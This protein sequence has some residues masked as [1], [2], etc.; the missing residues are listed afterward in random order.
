MLQPTGGWG[1][2]TGGLPPSLA[3][4]Q[5][6]AATLTIHNNSGFCSINNISHRL[7]ANSIWHQIDRWCRHLLITLDNVESS[8]TPT[9]KKT[10]CCFLDWP[11]L[12]LKE[13]TGRMEKAC[14]ECKVTWSQNYLIRCTHHMT[15]AY[16][17]WVK[18]GKESIKLI[19]CLHRS[20]ETVAMKTVPN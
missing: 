1:L 3:A 14:K 7:Q 11:L 17:L 2:G 18:K 13:R 4:G 5:A 9:M 20:L 10:D 12:S 19:L 15:E 16:E 8:T 6:A